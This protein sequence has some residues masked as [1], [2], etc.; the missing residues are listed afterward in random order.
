MPQR[1]AS[2]IQCLRQYDQSSSLSCSF[3]LPAC[4]DRQRFW[5]TGRLSMHHCHDRP[6]VNMDFA[7]RSALAS[8]RKA[9]RESVCFRAV[10]TRK[11]TFAEDT[12]LT[13]FVTVLSMAPRPSGRYSPAAISHTF[14]KLLNMSLPD[15]YTVDMFSNWLRK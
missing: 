4:L 12:P 1:E 10:N 7:S 15:P 3:S 6:G 5:K 14:L 2:C 8:A 9:G 11:L 13:R